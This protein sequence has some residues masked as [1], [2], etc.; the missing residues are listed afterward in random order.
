VDLSP[1][2]S[3]L[4]RVVADP[5]AASAARIVNKLMRSAKPGG[6]WLNT[7]TIVHGVPEPLLAAQI[8]FRGLNAYMPKQKLNLFQL[9]T[10]FMTQPRTRP[11]QI[12]RSNV[13]Q[14]AL[15][16]RRP[17]DIPYH[18]CSEPVPRHPAALVHLAEYWSGVDTSGCSPAVDCILHPLR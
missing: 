15:C 12:M 11:P 5:F 10:S 17:N 2:G 6:L 16:S 8:S 14:R 3:F 13:R 18:L 9:A 1:S 7:E 4:E